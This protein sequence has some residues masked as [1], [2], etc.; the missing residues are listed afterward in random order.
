MLKVGGGNKKS[1]PMAMLFFSKIRLQ[2][3]ESVHWALP[4]PLRP[5]IGDDGELAER[6]HRLR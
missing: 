2:W 3:F 4:Q 5:Q 1:T 6:V